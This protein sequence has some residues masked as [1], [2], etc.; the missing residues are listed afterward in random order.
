MYKKILA[1]CL[2]L[3][4]STTVFTGCLFSLSK[5]LFKA[6]T[7]AIKIE[8]IDIVDEGEN[9]NSDTFYRVDENYPEK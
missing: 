6:G 3:A 7:T 1:M 4:M 2:V 9:F 8:S 5:L